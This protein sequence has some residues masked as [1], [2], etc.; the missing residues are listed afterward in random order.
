MDVP[1]ERPL[2]VRGASANGISFSGQRKKHTIAH[3][4]RRTSARGLRPE[5]M[6]KPVRIQDR[7]FSII[8]VCLRG[9]DNADSAGLDVGL[10]RL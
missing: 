4:E 3:E 10:W 9:E 5:P 8:G 2:G 6:R 1:A 7:A